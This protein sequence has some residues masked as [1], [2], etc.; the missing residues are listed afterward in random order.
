MD[1]EW[2]CPLLEFLEACLGNRCLASGMV[3]ILAKRRVSWLS[4]MQ[5]GTASGTSE[6]RYIALSEAVEEDLALRQKV[7]QTFMQLL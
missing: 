4:R 5:A 6:A 1:S 3:V 2:R 7:V